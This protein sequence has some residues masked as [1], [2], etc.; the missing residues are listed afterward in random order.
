LGG[1]RADAGPFGQIPVWPHLHDLVEGT[2]LRVPEGRKGRVLLPVLVRLAIALLD[3]GQAAGLERVGADLVDHGQDLH[4]GDGSTARLDGRQNGPKEAT[5]QGPCPGR[6]AAR[7]YDGLGVLRGRKARPAEEPPLTASTSPV[8]N[9]ARGEARNSAALAMSSG[10][11]IRPHGIE[12]VSVSTY[13]LVSGDISLFT[14]MRPGAMQLTLM[15]CLAIS[16]ASTFVN[17]TTAAL[18]AQ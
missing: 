11:P 16:R 1:L 5:R 2:D 8:M 6:R 7:D 9:S 15:W 18:E 17:M 10:V 4:S 3:L 12:R 14:S 13:S